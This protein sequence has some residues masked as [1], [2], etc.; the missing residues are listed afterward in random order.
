MPDDDFP[1]WRRY[2]GVGGPW[3]QSPGARRGC[4]FALGAALLVIV[5][6]LVAALLVSLL[7]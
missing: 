1:Y 6:I 5:L 3:K 4:L 2:Y 7:G